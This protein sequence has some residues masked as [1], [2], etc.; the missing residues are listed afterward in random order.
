MP[1]RRTRSQDHITAEGEEAALL[2]AAHEQ[3]RAEEVIRDR[4]PREVLNLHRQLQHQQ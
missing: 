3:A 1:H 2:E 4:L